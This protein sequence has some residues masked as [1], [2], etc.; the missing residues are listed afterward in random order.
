MIV[1][2]EPFHKKLLGIRLTSEK[3]DNVIACFLNEFV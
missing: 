2:Y 1:A 3:R